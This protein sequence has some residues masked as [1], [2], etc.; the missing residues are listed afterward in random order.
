[1]NETDVSDLH[2]AYSF[3]AELDIKQNNDLFRVVPSTKKEN[4]VCNE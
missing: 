4:A 2:E 3:S 1:M